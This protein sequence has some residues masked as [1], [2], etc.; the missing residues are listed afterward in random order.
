[1]QK[2]GAR[3]QK[4]QPVF[5]IMDIKEIDDTTL[6]VRGLALAPLSFGKCLMVQP[7]NGSQVSVSW[8]I[9]RVFVFS[10]DVTDVDKGYYVE[11]L[12]KGVRGDLLRE[13][14]YLYSAA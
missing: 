10:R 7:M 8:E 3:V 1:M 4:P 14:L 5:E 6:R 2:A 9:L 11:L 13:N 12:L